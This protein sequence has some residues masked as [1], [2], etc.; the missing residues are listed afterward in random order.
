MDQ[1][2]IGTFIAA[3]RRERGLTQR[4][5]A[6]R[7]HV[8]NKA[9]SK[10]ELGRSLPDC[11]TLEPLAHALG[12]T[13]DELLCGQRRPQQAPAPSPRPQESPFA[14]YQNYVQGYVYGAEVERRRILGLVLLWAGIALLVGQ[15]IYLLGNIYVVFWNV[16]ALNA[17]TAEQLNATAH[18]MIFPGITL[19]MGELGTT[20][21][22][23][24]LWG[25]FL[26]GW[27]GAVLLPLSE[28]LIVAGAV[29]RRRADNA[30]VEKK[31]AGPEKSA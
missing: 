27:P 31:Q 7:L 22:L 13:V 20:V 9:V 14:L 5:L 11:A 19:I 10:W 3:V 30:P 28:A 16:D 17:L 1:Q 8:T 12:V 29:V 18:V 4:E 24:W 23:T 2:K 6:E 15:C 26:H 21:K 25:W